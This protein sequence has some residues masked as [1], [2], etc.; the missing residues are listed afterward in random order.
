MD[1]QI[2]TT[3]WFGPN[4]YGFIGWGVFMIGMWKKHLRYRRSLPASVN[5]DESDPTKD[6]E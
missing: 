4:S 5:S 1:R 2:G 6:G 3:I